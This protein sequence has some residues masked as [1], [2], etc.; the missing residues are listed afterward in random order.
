MA[1]L[2]ASHSEA[3]ALT[4]LRLQERADATEIS[5]AVSK[6]CRSLRLNAS[7]TVAAINC[8]L[9]AGGDTLSAARAGRQ[10]AAQLHHRA[11]QRT[12]PTPA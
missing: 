12:T 3:P 1:A 4:G 2:T 9:R 10:R 8:A 11:T 5:A 6:Y 7:D